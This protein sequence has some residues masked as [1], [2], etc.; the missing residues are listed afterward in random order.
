MTGREDA[1]IF[2]A[3]AVQAAPVYLDKSAT[4]EKACRL[5]ED[6]AKHG[7]RI[8]GFPECYIPGFPSWVYAASPIYDTL[9]AYGTYVENSILIRSTEIEMLCETAKQNDVYVVMGISEIDESSD[10]TLYITQVFIGRDGRILGKHRKIVPT[11]AE[12]LIFAN[13]DGSTLSVFK[14]EFGELGGLNCGEH[15]NPL[16]KFALIAQNLKIHV[17]SWP[18]P[19]AYFGAWRDVIIP[20][21]RTFAL[22]S[23]A[24]IINASGL[25]TPEIREKLLELSG[26]SQSKYKADLVLGGGVAC[27]VSPVFGRILAQA[28]PEREEIVYADCDMSEY[29]LTK[30]NHNILGNYNRPEI[31]QF[32]FNKEPFRLVN[33]RG[34]RHLNEA[35]SR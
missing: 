17:A 14:T 7:A 28:D 8:V 2:R 12:K 15:N 16:A 30:A 25:V 21:V 4:V 32:A 11:Y 5:I 18:M 27:V 6:S 33:I 22:E 13:G 3:A 34:E 20:C 9:K 23:K 19:G 35:Q 26:Q 24:F 10:S 29:Y 1:K 31:F